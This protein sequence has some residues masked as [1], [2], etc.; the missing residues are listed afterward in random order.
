MAS[1]RS[2]PI[3]RLL[4]VVG[5]ICVAL[6]LLAGHV[7]R[8]VFDGNTFA[9]NVD[10]IRRDPDV[11]EQVGLEISRQVVAAAPDL[12]ALRPLVDDVSVRVAG[13]SVLSGPVRQAARSAHD[14]LASGDGDAVVL[15]ITDAGAVVSA[16]LAAVAPD[17]AP[18]SADVSVTLAD[19][20]GEQVSEA[21]VDVSR[22]V[23]LLAWILPSAA[24][25]LFVAAIAL[26]PRRWQTAGAA[27]RSLLWA[28]GVLGALL[29]VGGWLVRRVDS[30]ELG[31]AVLRAS[32]TT[33][34]RPLWGSVATAAAVGLAVWVACDSSAPETFAARAA[35]LRDRLRTRPS[36]TTGLVVRL[37][38]AAAVGVAA[39]TDPMGLVEPLIVLGGVGL[40][41]FAVV[42][43][44]RVG[45]GARERYA[46]EDAASAESPSSRRRRPRAATYVVLVLAAVTVLA[47]TVFQARPGGDVEAVDPAGDIGCNGHDELCDRRY[48]EVAYA[49]SHNSMSVLNE[50]GWF[51]AEQTDPIPAQLDQGVRVL[52]VDVWSGRPGS[53]VVRTAASSYEEALAIANEELGPQVVDAA[54]RIADSI[55]GQATGPEARFMC[56]GLC[57]TG[58]TPWLRTLEQLRGWLVSNPSEVVTLFIEDHVAADLIA[59]DIVASGLVP[60]IAT[61]PAPGDPWPTLGEMVEADQ[62]LVVMLEEGVGG[63]SAPWMVNGF[64]Y[65]QDTP[66][67]FPSADDFSCDHNRGPDDASLLLLNHWL[68]NFTSLVT[69]AE[70]VNRRDV[71]LGRAEQCADERGQ[72]PNFVAV[73]YVDRGDLY[74]VVD[75]LNGVG[76]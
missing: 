6:G 35:Q 45:A 56:H 41:L 76:D 22:T 11:A 29:V 54:L 1:R 25:V 26:S 75:T 46:V 65:T 5:S 73:N 59:D 16:V 62:R 32:W 14:A 13:G 72:I 31:G 48:D 28:A 57:E 23:D 27:G 69:D 24:L 49:A 18:V 9:A 2:L 37:V 53:G 68:A 3:V 40:V 71:L 51:L 19:I 58:S 36:T 39:I 63:E 15:R 61:P 42:E 20:G 74:A 17:R 43:L 33:L 44:A 66:Y 38:V 4:L 10:E 55:A 50:P 64:D 30:A 60:L 8:Q 67:T 52:L 21:L 70:S 47:G 7:N 12:A 34:V